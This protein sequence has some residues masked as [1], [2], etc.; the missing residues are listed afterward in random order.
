M[1]W[2]ILTASRGRI[3]RGPRSCRVRGRLVDMRG[4][5]CCTC[6]KPDDLVPGVLWARNPPRPQKHNRQEARFQCTQLSGFPSSH[7]VGRG[8]LRYGRT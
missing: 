3:V 2:N 8:S 4:L 1:S 7:R 5:P 6:N